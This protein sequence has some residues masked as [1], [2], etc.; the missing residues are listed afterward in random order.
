MKRIIFSL[1]FVWATSVQAQKNIPAVKIPAATKQA[2]AKAHP[3]A[4]GKWEKEGGDYEVSFKENGKSMS[5]VIDQAGSIKETETVIAAKNFPAPV[6]NYIK[7]HYKG[8]KITEA[9][10]IVR[11]DGT[12]VYEAEIRGKDVLFDA[13]G[14]LLTTKKDND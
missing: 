6:S 3:Q 5:C 8:A 11:A 7:N 12:T 2:F 4:S 14:N 1:L 10:T 9:A 13:N